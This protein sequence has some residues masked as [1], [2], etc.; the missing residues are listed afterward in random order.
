[1]RAERVRG[2]RLSESEGKRKREEEGKD[3]TSFL[4]VEGVETDR[5]GRR[6]RCER[7]VREVQAYLSLSAGVI[8][9]RFQT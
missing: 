5:R 8:F 9:L 1:M 3:A 4:L 7:A 6:E 2:E